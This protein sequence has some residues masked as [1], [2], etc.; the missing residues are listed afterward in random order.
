MRFSWFSLLPVS[1][2]VGV[3]TEASQF[4]CVLFVRFSGTGGLRLLCVWVLG[5][6]QKPR[7]G[8]LLGRLPPAGQSYRIIN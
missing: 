8:T 3:N 7:I 5:G 1:S 2:F 6:A 4:A